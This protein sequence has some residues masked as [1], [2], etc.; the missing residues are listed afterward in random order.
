MGTA[1]RHVN[2]CEGIVDTG[3]RGAKADFSWE[4]RFV[5]FHTAKADLR[6]YEIVVV[7]QVRR[8]MRV[9]AGLEGSSLFPSW[10]ADGRLCFRYDGRDYRGFV[11]ASNVLSIPETSLPPPVLAAHDTLEWQ[12]V[13]PD[14]PTPSHRAALVVVWAPWSAHSPEALI[15]ADL[16][17]R[18]L[19]DQLADVYVAT[20][21][22]LSTRARDAALFRQQVETTLPHISLPPD[23]LRSSGALNQ[24]P[25]TLLFVGGKLI[26]RRLGAQSETDLLQWVQTSL[27]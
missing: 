19:R 12:D 5:A 14:V 18:Q 17:A 22:E 8:T 7:D 27:R 2:D 3:I 11:M 20:T 23:R 9:I 16:A 1:I 6:G 26:E 25:A 24:I 13:F 21:V 10:T 15:A 4:G